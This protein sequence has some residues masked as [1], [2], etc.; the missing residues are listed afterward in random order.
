LT[1]DNLQ[2]RNRK[3]EEGGPFTNCLANP[4]NITQE[5]G[6]LYSIVYNYKPITKQ[7]LASLLYM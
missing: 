6:Q 2:G 3:K 7:M 1:L 4:P 5:V